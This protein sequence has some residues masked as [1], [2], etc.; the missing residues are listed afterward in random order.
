[1]GVQLGEEWE[2][3]NHI[4]SRLNRTLAVIGGLLLVGLVL[5]WLLRRRRTQHDRLRNLFQEA[6]ARAGAGGKDATASAGAATVLFELAQGDQEIPR[7][8]ARVEARRRSPGAR[9]AGDR[10]GRP[11][12][13]LRSDTEELRTHLAERYDLAACLELAA[14]LLRIVSSD[15]VISRHEHRLM[16]RAADLLGMTLMTLRS[17]SPGQCELGNT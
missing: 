5:W 1:V 3:I 7:E 13:P 11:P 4:I 9:R 10:S 15:G 6:L 12:I 2:K 14:R 8:D 16:Q 17:P